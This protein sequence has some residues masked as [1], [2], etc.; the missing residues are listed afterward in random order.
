MALFFDIERC[1]RYKGD[2]LSLPDDEEISKAYRDIVKLIQT[3]DREMIGY[4]RVEDIPTYLFKLVEDL[5]DVFF[6]ESNKV[7]EALIMIFSDS[8]VDC[9]MDIKWVPLACCTITLVERLVEHQGRVGGKAL[10]DC[11]NR[12][13]KA[14]EKLYE[15]CER[16]CERYPNDS[17]IVKDYM[18]G[19]LCD[20]ILLFMRVGDKKRFAEK[21]RIMAEYDGPLNP[22]RVRRTDEEI[23]HMWRKENPTHIEQNP[24][25]CIYCGKFEVE[26]G[27]KKHNQCSACMNALYCSKKCQK[28]HWKQHKAGCKAISR[29]KNSA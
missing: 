17:Q 21:T 12:T 14:G 8:I 5:V 9:Y 15:L 18:Q 13:I 25:A 1:S 10:V 11:Y 22:R 26:N 3:V 19:F 23:W 6:S 27:G 16:I 29:S 20:A 7:K 24:F 4:E 28:S 2:L